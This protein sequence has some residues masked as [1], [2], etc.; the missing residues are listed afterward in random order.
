ME[1]VLVATSPS[2]RDD[3]ERILRS[4]GH[5]ALTLKEA[6]LE[7]KELLTKRMDAAEEVKNLARVFR[8]RGHTILAYATSLSVGNISYTPVGI[9]MAMDAGGNN[10]PTDKAIH[11]WCKAAI[12]RRGGI[13]PAHLNHAIAVAKDGERPA[14]YEFPQR[15]KI[16]A[17][18][19]GRVRDPAFPFSSMYLGSVV[20]KY[21]SEMTDTE[22]LE[23]ID[24]LRRL[25]STF[26][27]F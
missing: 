3:M 12:E 5:T 2:E 25:V 11:D 9:R 13:F 18:V 26:A 16:T 15:V 23:E 20:N 27:V 22:W 4:L 8:A 14:L 1:F 21:R 24:C 10:P 7:E 17:H 19:T 6:G